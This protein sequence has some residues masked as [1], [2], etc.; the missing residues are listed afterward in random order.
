[1][2]RDCGSL[3]VLFT[4]VI[5]IIVWGLAIGERLGSLSA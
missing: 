4:L 2:A 3:A 1:M 5:V